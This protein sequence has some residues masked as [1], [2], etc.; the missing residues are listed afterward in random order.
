[1]ADDQRARPVVPAGE[2]GAEAGGTIDDGRFRLF[3]QWPPGFFDQSE[4]VLWPVP[5]QFGARRTDVAGKGIT[6]PHDRIDGDG[7][8]ERG[9]NGAGGLQGPGVGGDD[10]TPYSLPQKLL[11]GV[12]GL[13]VTKLGQAR[14]DY[15]RVLAGGAKMQVEFALAVAQ[16]DHAPGDN[17][18]WYHAAS[19]VNA[20]ILGVFTRVSFVMAGGRAYLW[21]LRRQRHECERRIP[22]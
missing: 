4:I 20:A 3:L 15:A 9:G 8:A 13:G 2:G 22:D 10:N 1:M 14:V 21:L 17:R 12:G 11:G 7:Q 6:L 5:F 19:Q 16:Q 18:G